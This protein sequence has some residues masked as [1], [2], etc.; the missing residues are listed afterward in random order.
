[1]KSDECAGS[2]SGA[3]AAACS[4]THAFA[5][6]AIQIRRGARR[7]AVGADP[8]R[9]RRVERDEQQVQV[10]GLDAARQSDRRPAP[11]GVVRAHGSLAPEP[12][13]AAQRSPQEQR[14][15]RANQ[16]AA[17]TPNRGRPGSLIRSMI[18]AGPR[19]IPR[20]SPT[21]CAHH[22]GL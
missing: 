20:Y 6:D 3:G 17:A 4:N 7:P 10:R 19:S 8:I 12:P 9:P 15:R 21:T 5:G 14:Q 13:R 16:R 1:M 11:A 22:S 2:V 18:F